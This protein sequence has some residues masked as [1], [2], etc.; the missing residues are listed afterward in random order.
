[1]AIEEE[2]ALPLSPP[3]VKAA[4]KAPAKGGDGAEAEEGVVAAPRKR[5]ARVTHPEDVYKMVTRA[6][7]KKLSR[8]TYNKRVKREMLAPT[9][10]VNAAKLRLYV[11]AAALHA[12]HVGRTTIKGSDVDCSGT[13]NGNL[14]YA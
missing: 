14:V 9:Q 1:M 2:D 13:M 4:A 8:R 10:N 7:V 6:S 12:A 3:P 11:R 5:V